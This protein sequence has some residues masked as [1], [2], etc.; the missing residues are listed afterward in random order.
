MKVSKTLTTLLCKDKDFI[1]DLE[2]RSCKSP[3]I[4][5]PSFYRLE[6]PRAA[7]PAPT[8][9]A[10]EKHPATPR[11]T[12]MQTVSD[13]PPNFVGVPPP[14]ENFGQLALAVFGTSRSGLPLG[15]VIWGIPRP[16]P[17]LP[18]QRVSP[19]KRES[20]RKRLG[21]GGSRGRSLASEIGAAA[22]PGAPAG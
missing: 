18:P 19:G 11:T 16:T 14:G 12:S 22:L 1:I 15:R 20:P 10:Q 6:T 9:A 2:D 3:Q 21:Y 8:A 7:I 17:S 5:C 4:L 13:P